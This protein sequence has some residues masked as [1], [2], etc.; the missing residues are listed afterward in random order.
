[1]AALVRFDFAHRS[2]EIDNHRVSLASFEKNLIQ[3]NRDFELQRLLQIALVVSG[4]SEVC[5]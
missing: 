1:L 5:A 2:N 4:T 3:E